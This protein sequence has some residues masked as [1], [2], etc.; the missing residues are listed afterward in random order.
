[1]NIQ[2][3]GCSRCG[4]DLFPD[5]SDRSGETMVCL[6]CGVEVPVARAI[7]RQLGADAFARRRALRERPGVGLTPAA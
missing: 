6:Q 4:G 3:K 5:A 2:L 1:M 7:M